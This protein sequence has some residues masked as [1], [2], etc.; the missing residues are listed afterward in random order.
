MLRDSK[1]NKIN[2]ST[3][4]LCNFDPLFCYR[5][6]NL[7]NKELKGLSQYIKKRA[8]WCKMK[9]WQPSWLRTPLAASPPLFL[10]RSG[11]GVKNDIQKID[12]GFPMS[13]SCYLVHG[14]TKYS[15]FHWWEPTLWL[16]EDSTLNWW[17]IK[18]SYQLLFRA[19]LRTISH[20][21]YNIFVNRIRFGIGEQYA[22]LCCGL[23]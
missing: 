21:L 20:Y 23:I 4:F 13:C 22:S 17:I 14:Q 3:S 15:K 16:S 2:K 1:I 18:K 6:M 5:K 12:D 8:F 11:N 7:S 19:L 9:K 10:D